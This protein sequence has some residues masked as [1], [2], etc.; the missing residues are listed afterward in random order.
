MPSLPSPVHHLFSLTHHLLPATSFFLDL[1]V[2]CNNPFIHLHQPSVRFIPPP[3]LAFMFFF[4][5][6]FCCRVP[7]LT[8][9]KKGIARYLAKPT[10]VSLSELIS[11]QDMDYYWFSGFSIFGG[12]LLFLSSRVRSSPIPNRSFSSSLSTVLRHQ[13]AAV[14]M[15]GFCS[16]GHTTRRTSSWRLVNCV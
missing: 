11:D 14:F 3:S 9:F 12:L 7:R 10:M 16:S 8:F 2:S 4:V 13:V 5:C 6:F 1:R 15:T